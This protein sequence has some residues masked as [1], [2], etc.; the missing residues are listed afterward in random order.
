MSYICHVNHF[1]SVEG[2]EFKV[3]INFMANMTVFPYLT[4]Q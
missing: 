4:D 2:T 1:A 3:H